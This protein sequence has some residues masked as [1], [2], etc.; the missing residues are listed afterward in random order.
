MRRRARRARYSIEDTVYSARRAGRQGRWSASQWWLALSS[1]TR[2]LLVGAGVAVVA[3]LALVLIVVPNL[4]C[5]VPGGD[6]CPPDDDAI[7]LVP[8]DATAYAHV[9]TDRESEQYEQAHELAERVPTLTDQLVRQLPGP[10]G[11]RVSYARDV[12]PWL[13][14]EAA[15]ALVP[16]GAGSPRA[17]ALLEVGDDRG[18]RR[19]AEEVTGSDVDTDAVGDVAVSVGDGAAVARVDDFLVVGRPPQVKQVVETKADGESLLD[20]EPADE[21]IDALPDHRLAILYASER[22]ADEL[23]APGE[24]LGSF[25][26]FVN[27]GATRGAAAALVTGSDSIEVAVHSVIDPERAEADPGFFAALP[28]FEPELAGEV[29]EDALAYLALGDPAASLSGLLSQAR[30]GAPGLA[31]A[32][33]DFSRQL[34]SGGEVSLEDDLLPLLTTQAAITIEPGEGGPGDLAGAPYV[35][36]VS[37]EIDADE[38]ARTLDRLQGAIAESLAEQ[39][40]V[41][42][43]N[44]VDG[45]EVRSLQVSQAVELAYA[46]VDDRLV[47]S[48]DPRGIARVVGDEPDIGESD[49]YEAATEGFADEVSALLYLNVDGLL[50]LAEQAGL[51]EDPSYVL[52]RE[53]FRTLDAL[54]LAVERGENELDT[55][56]RLAIRE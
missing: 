19:F 48:T 44:E 50:D 37:G 35:T 12:A 7:E 17:T 23:L 10:D 14:G 41:F 15:L 54:G 21:A 11:A 22:G 6:Q 34:R 38:A 3:L 24:P 13:G 30:A 16:A 25:E 26:T 55:R 46:I 53:E 20:S 52:F 47:V 8:A 9:D 2:A 39:G 1:D 31:A 56:M 51:Q 49:R 33:E 18:A 29:S 27:A 45:V 42:R 4:P 5:A 28:A 32:F 36:L 43:E 40:E